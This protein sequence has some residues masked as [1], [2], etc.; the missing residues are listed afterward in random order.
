M[1]CLRFDILF[2]EINV[3][4]FWKWILQIARN[5]AIVMASR[6]WF[7]ILAVL[8]QGTALMNR[9]LYLVGTRDCG[10]QVCGVQ[11][12]SIEMLKNE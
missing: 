11:W 9:L 8:G 2:I 6:A 3:T 7:L 4:F 5:P 12:L 1:D 10:V